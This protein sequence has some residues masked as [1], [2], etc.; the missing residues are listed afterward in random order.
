MTE[1]QKASHEWIGIL[2]YYYLGR[3]AKIF[4]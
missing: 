4:N 2:S 3:S 1:F